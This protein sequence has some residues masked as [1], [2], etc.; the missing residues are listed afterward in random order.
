[1]K[2]GSEEWFTQL[3]K[4]VNF[5]TNFAFYYN[6][7]DN[8]IQVSK[9]DSKAKTE[10]IRYKDVEPSPLLFHPKETAL[11]KAKMIYTDKEYY[12]EL[13]KLQELWGTKFK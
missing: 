7:K 9:V 13:L 5:P 3:N 8:I 12:K 2:F 11:I 10:N 4:M 1:M 6:K